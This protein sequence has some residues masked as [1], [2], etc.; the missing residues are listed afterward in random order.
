MQEDYCYKVKAKLDIINGLSNKKEQKNV[1]NRA[2]CLF[3]VVFLRF[4]R[5]KNID[6]IN[7]YSGFSIFYTSFSF[8][9]FSTLYIFNVKLFHYLCI[10]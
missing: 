4:E 1:L 5:A 7:I 6:F 2:F 10:R 8:Y 9:Y 3:F